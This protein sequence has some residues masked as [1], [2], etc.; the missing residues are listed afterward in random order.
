MSL[1]ARG[2][3]NTIMQGGVLRS[4]R[5][6]KAITGIRS[7]PSV[8]NHTTGTPKIMPPPLVTRS[9]RFECSVT[10]PTKCHPPLKQSNVR[11]TVMWLNTVQETGVPE[12]SRKGD[13]RLPGKE[14]SNSHGARP[15]H[16]IISMTSWIRTSRLS[17]KKSLSGDL[18]AVASREVF[19]D[20][21]PPAPALRLRAS[22]LC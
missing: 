22:Y 7:R 9:Q 8:F 20:E 19:R 10:P 1:Y 3:Q 11:V 5:V 17:T 6:A 21:C 4:C 16:L 15:V 2:T 13:V 18:L 14:N 12:T